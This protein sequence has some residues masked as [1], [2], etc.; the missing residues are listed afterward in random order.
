MSRNMVSKA[1]ADAT[2]SASGS[3]VSAEDIRVI[4]ENFL[5]VIIDKVKAGEDVTLTNLIKFERILTKE[6]TFNVPGKDTKTTKPERYSLRIKV[7]AG[8][9]K[10]FEAIAVN[11]NDNDSDNEPAPA[12]AKKPATKSKAKN[13]ILPVESDDEPPKPAKSKK[14]EIQ[15]VSDDE[16]EPAP[17]SKKPASKPKKAP[18]PAPKKPVAPKPPVSDDDDDE[19]KKPVG[20][21]FDDS[22][23]E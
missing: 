20:W 15:P 5:T 8:V 4:C 14:P 18:A 6:R 19:P 11:D 21:Q 2:K 16:E 3:S 9:K 13:E 1:L 7:M 10:S 22:D 12:P 23:D 17:K